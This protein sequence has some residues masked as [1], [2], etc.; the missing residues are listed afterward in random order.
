MAVMHKVQL[1]SFEVPTSVRLKMPPGLRQD[2]ICSAP[3]IKIQDLDLSTVK[4]LLEEFNETVLAMHR[5]GVEARIRED[6]P[7]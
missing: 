6:D 7:T 1:S 2:G 4:E 3:E 5:R